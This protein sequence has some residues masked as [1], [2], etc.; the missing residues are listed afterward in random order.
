MH[1]SIV[2]TIVV[3]VYLLGIGCFGIYQARK[4][5]GS[6]D[7]FAGGR[8][9]NKFMMMMHA[10]GTGTHADDPVG[11]SGAAYQR[12][13]SGIWYTFIYLFVTP[14]Y[15]LIAPVFRRARFLTTSDFFEARFGSS[16][17][18]LYTIMGVLTFTINMGTMLK[19]TGMLAHAIS[20]GAVPEWLAIAVM[21]LVFVAYGTAGGL[22]AT[23]YAESIQGLLIVVM[24]LLLV[25]FGLMRVGGFSG[26]HHLVDA[27]K[28]SLSAP[29]EMSIPWIVAASVAALIGIVAQ[30]QTM[31]V[32]S[33]GKTEWEGR[34][35]YTYGSMIKRFCALGWTMTGVIFIAMVANGSVAGLSHREECFG[36][37]IRAL[38]PNGLTGLM[39]AAILAAQMAALS[40]FMVAASALLSRNIYRKW[41]RPAATDKDVVGFARWSGLA[42]VGVGA[43]VAFIVPGV[44]DALTY[45]WAI[46]SFTGLF[47]WSG[48][49]WRRTNATGAWASFLVMVTIWVLVGP[50]GIELHKLLPGVGWLGIYGD[51]TCL[52]LLILSYLPAGIVALVV[53]S[54][55]GKPYDSRKLDHFY[56]LLKTPVGQEEKLA[57]AGVDVVYAGSSKGHPWELNHPTLVN[58][59][60]FIVAFL[61]SMSF[62]GML[63]ILA[64][65]GG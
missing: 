16:L 34:V 19:G 7:Y 5:R 17:G 39:F 8:S 28:F 4:I 58:V 48:V 21:T 43:F 53:G 44:A 45:F 13:F 6:G 10:L 47:I 33:T 20:Q 57:K 22:L 26:L 59:L 41:M 36:A 12:G 2:D 30:P 46:A 54:L 63:Y 42:V 23:V 18:L 51:K 25:P 37:A 31:E 1:L 38:L 35:G 50:I 9:F 52:H 24:S 60:G 14:F 3:V 32:C 64:R 11:V 27:S 49:L 62:L 40:A 65:I 55:L 61:I 15:W 56:L 29:V